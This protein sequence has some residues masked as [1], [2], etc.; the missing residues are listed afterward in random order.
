ME[1]I[2][3]P[4]VSKVKA[5][6][7]ISDTWG[8]RKIYYRLVDEVKDDRVYYYSERDEYTRRFS[9]SLDGFQAWAYR[10]KCKVKRHDRWRYPPSILKT[11]LLMKK[12]KWVR[13]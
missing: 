9:C 10:N 7:L 4:E 1:E 8:T 11:F 6:I 12:S 3:P 13:G 2:Y 5:K